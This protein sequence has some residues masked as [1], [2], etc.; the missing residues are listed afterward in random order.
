MH[1]CIIDSSVFF[2]NKLLVSQISGIGSQLDVFIFVFLLFPLDTVQ[3]KS[4]CYLPIYFSKYDWTRVITLFSWLFIF[5]SFCCLLVDSKITHS[6]P[7]PLL[8]ESVE[9]TSRTR[10]K[11]HNSNFPASTA[12]PIASSEEGRTAPLL[13]LDPTPLGKPSGTYLYLA[14]NS[15]FF[16]CIVPIYIF[17]ALSFIIEWVNSVTNGRNLYLCGSVIKVALAISC[18]ELSRRNLF[19][20]FISLL[21]AGMFP[22]L[23]YIRRIRVNW[24]YHLENLS[25]IHKICKFTGYRVLL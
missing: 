3:R 8:A 4:E 24:F 7:S 9:S 15:I 21:Y 11:S 23:T 1:T 10:E 6:S 14:L 20:W 25:G 19:L 2:R 16:V 5:T 17:A 18:I 12:L 22:V 13:N